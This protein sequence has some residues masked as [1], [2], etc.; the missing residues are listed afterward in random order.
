[1]DDHTLGG[2]PDEL[3]RRAIPVRGLESLGVAR[4]EHRGALW[5]SPFYGV[6]RWAGADPQNPATEVSDAAALLPDG[7]ALGGWAA[8]YNRGIH[9]L[10]GNIGFSRPLPV[11]LLAVDGH[12]LRKREGVRPFRTRVLPHDIE[13]V[14]G[15]ATAVLDLAARQQMCLS[16]TLVDAVVVA[17]MVTSVRT[18]EPTIPMADLAKRVLATKRVRGIVQAR[19]ALELATD[20]SASPEES[21]TRMVWVLDAFLPPPLVN[22][23]LFDLDGGLLGFGDLVDPEA[24]HVHEVDGAQHRELDQHTADNARE[25]LFE[26]HGLVVSRSTSR[27]RADP[28]RLAARMRATNKRGRARDRTRDRWTLTP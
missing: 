10:D 19:T 18:G 28:I 12:Q 5:E 25:E 16:R 21:R 26:G 17:D 13:P 14:N 2:L 15:L 8:A 7:C 27:D 11:L 3:V 22:A 6:R 24:G 1:M 20:R 4:H 23:P 9:Y